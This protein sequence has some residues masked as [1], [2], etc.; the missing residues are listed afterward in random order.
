MGAIHVIATTITI[1]VRFDP[2]GREEALNLIRR[3]TIQ[4]LTTVIGRG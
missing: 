2:H 3:I 1:T 4:S